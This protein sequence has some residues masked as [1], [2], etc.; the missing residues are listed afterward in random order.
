M[1]YRQ[2]QRF[3]ITIHQIFESI[4]GVSTIADDIIIY[5]VTR[6]AHDNSLQKTLEIARQVNLKMNRDKCEIGVTQLTFI[7]DL[8]TAEGVKPDPQKVTAFN[9]MVK[10][11]S[12]QELQSFL[13]MVTDSA[14]WVV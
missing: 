13:G 6:E 5:G 3:T 1:A 9:N 14:K 4:D 8:V 7:G 2:H 10:P 12:K 11:E